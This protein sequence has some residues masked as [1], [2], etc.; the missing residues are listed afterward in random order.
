M[1][2]RHMPSAA[3]NPSPRGRRSGTST[4]GRER[5]HVLG[6]LAAGRSQWGDAERLH[7]EA[8]A[9]ITERGFRRSCRARWRRWPRSPPGS[10]A[11]R[12]RPR[13]S[14][15][16]SGRGESL[17]SS[18]GSA[19]Q[20]AHRPHRTRARSAR[21]GRRSR[22][23]GPRAPISPRTRSSVGR[24]RRAR[25]SR[26]RPSGGWESLTPTELE[27][28]RHAAAGLTNPEIGE[29]MFISRGTVKI[30][31]SHIYAKLGVRNRSEVAAEAIRRLEAE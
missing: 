12:R 24:V 26:K 25:G 4:S 16:P 19:A 22:R 14:R 11:T 15:P 13:C 3:C 18:L 27:V 29:R 30:H 28:V 17:G 7:H 9:M 2:P 23:H 21:R 1:G 5:Y 6:R 20:G 10:R 31:L 8:L